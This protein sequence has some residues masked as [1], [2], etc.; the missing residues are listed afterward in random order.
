MTTYLHLRCASTQLAA[1]SKRSAESSNTGS[2]VRPRLVPQHSAPQ[3]SVYEE[4][5][6]DAEGEEAGTEVPAT[7]AKSSSIAGL[8]PPPPAHAPV[9]HGDS[10][11]MAEVPPAKPAAILPGG[12]VGPRPSRPHAA[13]PPAQAL[14]PPAPT[15]AH[16]AAGHGLG[17]GANPGSGLRLG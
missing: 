4:A 14:G 13:M 17:A 1:M 9:D 10:G 16:S 3:A 6:S 8:P 11:R 2:S 7:M 5:S 15:P 12:T